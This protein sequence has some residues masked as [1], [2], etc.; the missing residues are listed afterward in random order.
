MS[1]YY[2]MELGAGIGPSIAGTEHGFTEPLRRFI[3]RVSFE[4]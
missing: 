3:Q 1:R 4:P 2:E